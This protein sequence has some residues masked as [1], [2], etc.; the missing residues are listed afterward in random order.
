MGFADA[1]PIAKQIAEALAGVD[2]SLSDDEFGRVLEG[3]AG[4]TLVECAEYVS[5]ARGERRRP[6]TGWASLTPTELRV[7]AL[8]ADGL[9]NAQIGERL[10]IAAGTAKIHIA[11]IFTKLDIT[12]RAQLAAL[13]TARRFEGERSSGSE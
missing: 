3:S 11:H 12:N 7:A 2:R 4:L 9:T 10:F 5:R 8:A 1:L 6:A 13:A